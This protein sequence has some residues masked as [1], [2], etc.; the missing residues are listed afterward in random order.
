MTGPEDPSIQ[1]FSSVDFVGQCMIDRERT[2]A[3]QRAI[4]A[5]VKPGMHVLDIGTGSG[6]LSILAARA[7]ARKITALEFDP[8]IA[9][10]AR[11]N[12]AANSYE[13]VVHFVIGDARTHN[14]GTHE[15]FDVIVAELL[16]TGVV[17]E[18]QVQVMNNLHKHKVITPQ[19]ILIPQ[20]QETYAALGYHD[21]RRYDLNL[22]IVKHLW[23][24]HKPEDVAV[25][26][27]TK[28]EL[29]CA[30]DFRNVNPEDISVTIPYTIQ[31]DGEVNILHLSSRTILTDTESV[32][33]TDALN[34]PMAIPIP[35]TRVKEGE[36]IKVKI[37]Y[38]HG[39]GYAHFKADFVS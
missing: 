21:Y 35:P 22:P 10:V 19:T 11:R 26:F 15:P 9:E 13:D 31:K 4:E 7:G 8:F 28:K 18:Y 3:F 25:N 29:V 1:T 20:I 5:S 12:F 34:A 24:F 6:I 17:D 37:S 14:F 23:R 39:A 33:D 2:E 27:Y 36:E 30:P 32:E 38:R 16:T